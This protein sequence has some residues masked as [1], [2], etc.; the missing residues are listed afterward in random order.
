MINIKNKLVVNKNQNNQTA[1]CINNSRS[2]LFNNK[3]DTANSVFESINNKNKQTSLQEHQPEQNPSLQEIVTT[4]QEDAKMDVQEKLCSNMVNQE[5]SLN[6]FPNKKTNCE[7]NNLINLNEKT[8]SKN[9][10]INHDE[11][12]QDGY[13]MSKNEQIKNT[14]KIIEVREQ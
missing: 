4:Q 13:L 7:F 6:N 5:K 1:K 11:M 9:S 14:H 8:K 2:P 12:K 10:K 3:N